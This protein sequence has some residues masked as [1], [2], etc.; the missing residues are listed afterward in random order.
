M[1]RNYTRQTSCVPFMHRHMETTQ[2]EYKAPGTWPRWVP[3]TYNSPQSSINN[4][5]SAPLAPISRDRDEDQTCSRRHFRRTHHLRV[6]QNL[7]HLFWTPS[8]CQLGEYPLSF[9]LTLLAFALQKLTT[10]IR[11]STIQDIP[12][13]ASLKSRKAKS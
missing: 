10:P 9:L 11:R 8:S 2:L 3:R 4:T 13:H 12:H 7:L 6:T 5:G 1:L